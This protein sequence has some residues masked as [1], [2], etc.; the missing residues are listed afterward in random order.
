MRIIHMEK[1][2]SI[3][4]S[5]SCH[6][7][8]KAKRRCKPRLPKCERCRI[9]GVECFYTNKSLVSNVD[10]KQPLSDSNPKI[11]E[12]LEDNQLVKSR[13]KITSRDMDFPISL[14]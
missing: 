6:A 9:K 7:C 3:S 11:P 4:L 1:V 10:D 14:I 12:I 8:I 5:R 2:N 13:Q